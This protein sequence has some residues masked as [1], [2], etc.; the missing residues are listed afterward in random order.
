M[1][2]DPLGPLG[3]LFA[4]LLGELGG[5]AEILV[6]DVNVLRDDRFDPAADTVGRFALGNPDWLEQIMDVARLD[7]GDREI[8][9]RG[10]DPSALLL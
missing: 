7:L 10:V 4:K 5:I 1:L 6:V 9:D 2:H 8:T 3:K